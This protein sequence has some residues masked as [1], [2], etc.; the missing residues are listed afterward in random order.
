M[1]ATSGI[2]TSVSVFEVVSNKE[3]N[4]LEGIDGIMECIYH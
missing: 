1:I 4:E 3:S 2:D